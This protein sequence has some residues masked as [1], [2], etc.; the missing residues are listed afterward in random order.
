MIPGSAL[1][2]PQHLDGK[3]VAAGKGTTNLRSLTRYAADRA[4]KVSVIETIDTKAACT[5]VSQGTTSAAALNEISAMGWSREQPQAAARLLD[6]YLSTKPVAV[7]L[8]K[9]Y[10]EFVRVF[11]VPDELLYRTA[12]AL[13]L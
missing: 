10:P 11:F 5:T 9:H 12:F 3:V 13:M 6:R 7:G 1:Q 8:P 4:L 2:S